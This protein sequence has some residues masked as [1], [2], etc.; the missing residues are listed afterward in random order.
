MDVGRYDES[1]TH[2]IVHGRV[3]VSSQSCHFSSKDSDL[4]II[5][6][7]GLQ[8]LLVSSWQKVES[9]LP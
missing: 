9:C 6:G 1:C 7:N 3:Y 8:S 4:S 5:T 2:V